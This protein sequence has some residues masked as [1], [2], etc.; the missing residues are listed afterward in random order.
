VRERLALDF[1]LLLAE[2]G[3]AAHPALGV[4]ANRVQ[5]LQ[6]VSRYLSN[7]KKTLAAS[8][9]RYAPNVVS[10]TSFSGSVLNANPRQGRTCLTD[11]NFGE[12][13][14]V[15]E[16]CITLFERVNDD[17][18][19]ACSTRR[20][21]L[22]VVR[23]PGNRAGFAGYLAGAIRRAPLDV[24]DPARRIKILGSSLDNST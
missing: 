15:D 11:D 23:F 21:D 6:A 9:R 10:Q 4:N 16:K 13:I 22:H 20:A 24:Q 5:I 17:A 12:R 2:V 14:P 8:Y 19:P 3:S 7:R 1:V 18:I